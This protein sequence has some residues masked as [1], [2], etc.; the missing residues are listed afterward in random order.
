MDQSCRTPLSLYPYRSPR[1]PLFSA[2]AFLAQSCSINCCAR[3]RTRSS[4][5]SKAR[6]NGST[7]PGGASRAQA[8]RALSRTS[9]LGELS[10]WAIDSGTTKP[11]TVCPGSE[12]R[13][14]PV[15]GLSPPGTVPIPDAG[16]GPLTEASDESLDDGGDAS[17]RGNGPCLDKGGSPILVFCPRFGALSDTGDPQA[18]SPPRSIKL[19]SSA[20]WRHGRCRDGCSGG[21]FSGL[22]D[23]AGDE[24][25]KSG[26]PVGLFFTKNTFWLSCICL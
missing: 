14:G 19:R 21:I 20:R 9:T 10:F 4:L 24:G 17:L 25:I 16:P 7:A 8:S 5:S 18:V 12:D 13:T 3:A 1:S 23:N 6:M 15:E 11:P 22:S 26:V 2:S